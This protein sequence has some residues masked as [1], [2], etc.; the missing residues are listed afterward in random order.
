MCTP[1]IKSCDQGYFYKDSTQGCLA[2]DN[3]EYGIANCFAC[4]KEY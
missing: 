1:E 4:Y 3:A 2:C